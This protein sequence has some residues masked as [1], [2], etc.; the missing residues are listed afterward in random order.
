VGGSS[1]GKGGRFLISSTE[2]KD[3]QKRGGS[4]FPANP[5]D[6]FPGRSPGL[7]SGCSFSK[8]FP[9]RPRTETSEHELI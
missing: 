8:W 5:S 1:L 9:A 7:G 2:K 4:Q 6:P 3:R